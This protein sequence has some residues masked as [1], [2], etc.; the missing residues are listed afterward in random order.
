[1]LP[2]GPGGEVR[3]GVAVAVNGQTAAVAAEGPLGQPNL[4]LD[5]PAS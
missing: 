1:M 5:Q 4:L 3:G 2:L